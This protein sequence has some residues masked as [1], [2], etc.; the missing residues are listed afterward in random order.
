M[1]QK[2]KNTKGITLVALIITIIV[3]LILAVVAI[4]SISNSNII[5][6]AQNGKD[7][8]E[9]GKTNETE[10][11]AEYE[12]YLDEKNPQKNNLDNKE[13]DW[14]YVNMGEDVDAIVYIGNSKEITLT[15]DTEVTAF[16]SESC[17]QNEDTGEMNVKLGGNKI[18]KKI[19]DVGTVLLCAN[20]L[21]WNIYKD[22][23]LFKTITDDDATIEKVTADGVADKK[24]KYPFLLKEF[25]LIN[26]TEYGA[27]KDQWDDTEVKTLTLPDKLEKING[28]GFSFFTKVEYL[29]I[30]TSVT[31]V[32]GKAFAGW[33]ANQTIDITGCD[34][35]KWDA[36][37]KEECNAQIVGEQ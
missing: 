11:L 7:A 27:G 29:K 21:T 25:A 31:Y 19:S 30:P 5:K 4:T 14:F 24:M 15:K 28:F 37:W 23:T 26:T 34:K 22:N 6:H 16:Q 32:V 2:L 12:S 36:N 10:K 3:L 13:T 8:Y 17:E 33:S 1:K 18:N 9:Q 35:S 20:E